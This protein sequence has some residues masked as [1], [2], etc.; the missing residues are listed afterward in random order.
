MSALVA[1]YRKNSTQTAGGIC[2]GILSSHPAR[3]TADAA[4]E[5]GGFPARL[6]ALKLL[7][8][9]LM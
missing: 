2:P 6:Y 5:I 7:Q 4:L 3:K 1:I 8:E 9:W